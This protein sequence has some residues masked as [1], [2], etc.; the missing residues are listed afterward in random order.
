[1]HGVCIRRMLLIDCVHVVVYPAEWCEL[2][3]MLLCIVQTA[4]RLRHAVVRLKA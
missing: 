2:V 1:M 4:V 3:C